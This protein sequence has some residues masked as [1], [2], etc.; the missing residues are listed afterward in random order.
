MWRVIT[1]GVIEES[2]IRLAGEKNA[3]VTYSQAG[4]SQGAGGLR[5]ATGGPV[6]APD[7]PAPQHKAMFIEGERLH[8]RL[9]ERAYHLAEQRGF[10]PGDDLDDWLDAEGEVEREWASASDDPTPCGE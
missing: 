9:S 8:A 7:E 1:S 10:E 4:P 3:Q 2:Q 5:R 6:E